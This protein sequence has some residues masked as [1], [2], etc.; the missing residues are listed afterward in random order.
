[1]SEMED[2]PHAA[3]APAVPFTL[4]VEVAL[5]PA[6]AI[7][8]GTSQKAIRRRIEEGTWLEGHEYHRR[9]GRVWIDLRGVAEW[10]RG[11]RAAA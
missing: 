6:A 10:V 2:Q 8:L 4:Y 5:I 1:M 7:A 9:E 3:R 11:R